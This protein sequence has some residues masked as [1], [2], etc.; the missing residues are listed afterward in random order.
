MFDYLMAGLVVVASDLPSLRGVIERSGGGVCFEPGNSGDL[1]ATILELRDNR[2]LRFR[3]AASARAFAMGTAN[4][5]VEM[6]KFQATFRQVMEL[7][8]PRRDSTIST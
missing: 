7:Q 5:E 2:P 8:P 6:A 4:R 1:A 3:L